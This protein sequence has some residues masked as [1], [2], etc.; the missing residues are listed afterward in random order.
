MNEYNHHRI[1]E[2]FAAACDLEESVKNIFKKSSDFSDSISAKEDYYFY[3]NYYSIKNNNNTIILSRVKENGGGAQNHSINNMKSAGEKKANGDYWLNGW[4][5]LTDEKEFF[6]SV[7]GKK[8]S[9]IYDVLDVANQS[10]NVAF[11]HAMSSKNEDVSVARQY[12][13]GH[14]EKCFYE[15][16]FLKN[17]EDAL[18]A[19]GV[20]FHGIMDSFTP[21]HTGFQNYC[22]Q[23]MAIHAQGDVIPI[24]GSFIEEEGSGPLFVKGSEQD[25]EQ[26]VFIPGQYNKEKGKAQLFCNLA[27]GYN[28]NE[29]LNDIEYEMLKVFIIISDITLITDGTR[30]TVSNGKVD[31]NRT[32]FFWNSFRGNSLSQ[33]NEI[34]S[35]S[36]KY[37]EE[38]Y[39]YAETLISLLKSIYEKL[40]E[41]RIRIHKGGNN[42]YNRYKELKQ[43]TNVRTGEVLFAL[44]LWQ[45]AYEKLH[46]ENQTTNNPQNVYSKSKINQLSK[47]F[48]QNSDNSGIIK[49]FL[50][51]TVDTISAVDYIQDI[52]SKIYG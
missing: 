14:L 30:L 51:T 26:L 44:R 21:S 47:L 11:L 13:M 19:L 12:F 5:T 43:S 35:S 45:D 27:K 33:I 32:N 31:I 39:I 46:N 6:T 49:P 23:S 9:K 48:V 8:E 34:L 2:R 7:N 25:E 38:S 42:S 4:N 37:G 50:D 17:E 15:Y 36:Y 20:A 22:N 52:W 18:F 10:D 28:D 29:S 24:R 40:S 3:R 1:I 41:C 16:L